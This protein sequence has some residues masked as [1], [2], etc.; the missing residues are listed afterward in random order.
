MFK[1]TITLVLLVCLL[2]TLLCACGGGK[3]IT[4]QE[5]YQIVLADLGD[6][7]SSATAPH[8]HEGTHGGKPCFNIYVTVNGMGMQYV[9]SNTGKIISKG[10]G[11]HSH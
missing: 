8:I 9:I 7:A 5:A 3:E 6:L 4:A 2:G 10:P 1:K 11:G